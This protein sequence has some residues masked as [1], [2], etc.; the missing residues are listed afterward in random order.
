ML[1]LDGRKAEFDGLGEDVGEGFALLRLPAAVLESQ[2]FGADLVLEDVHVAPELRD[3][4]AGQ[5]QLEPQPAYLI[6]DESSDCF[7]LGNVRIGG[8][9]LSFGQERNGK[10]VMGMYP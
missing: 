1:S 7:D 4:V 6:V 8:S 3:G 10:S 9:D 5:V 2:L